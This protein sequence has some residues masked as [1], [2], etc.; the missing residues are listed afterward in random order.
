MTGYHRFVYGTNPVLGFRLP[1]SIFKLLLHNQYGQ[2]FDDAMEMY[3]L[4][5]EIYKHA[6]LDHSSS[7]SILP[8]G[9]QLTAGVDGSGMG[10]IE[11]NV[12]TDSDIREEIPPNSETDLRLANI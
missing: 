8:D 9:G 3:S 2:R 1:I 4:I 7:S 6:T 12:E 5:A 10:I 11:V